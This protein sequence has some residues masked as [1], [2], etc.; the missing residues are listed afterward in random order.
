MDK[1][2]T[3]IGAGIIPL[4]TAYYPNCW[5]QIK[6]FALMSRSTDLMEDIA[7]A[8]KNRINMTRRGYALST[9]QNNI[10]SLIDELND[11]MDSSDEKLLRYHTNF[12]VSGYAKSLSH[13]WKT[14]PRGVDQLQ[15]ANLYRVYF[16]VIQRMSKA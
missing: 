9:R 8:T 6:M 2:I 16:Q 10:D 3:I 12:T 11:G 1:Q 14:A 13:H 5:P 7:R 15:I 4:S